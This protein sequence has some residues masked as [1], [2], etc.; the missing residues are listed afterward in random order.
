[1][2]VRISRIFIAFSLLFLMAQEAQAWGFFTHKR[3]NRIAVF[4]LPPEMI[5]FYKA[6]IQF[7]TENAVNPDRRRYAVEGEA[8]RHYIDLDIYGENAFDIIPHKWEDAVAKYSEDTLLEY[9]IV[10]WHIEK[11]V[12][13]LTDAMRKRD[14]DRILLL[15]AD[16]GHYV[17]DCNVPLHTTENYNGHMTNQSGIHGFWESRLPELFFDEYDLFFETRATYEYDPLE[18]AWAAV[19]NAH[20]ALD[21][22]FGF[23]KQLTKEMGEDQ[24]WSF[25]TRGNITMKVY[26]VPFSKAYHQRLNGQV[27]RHLRASIKMTADLWYTCWL[28]AGKPDLKS[29]IPKGFSPEALKEL[30]EE[31][32]KWR[33]RKIKSREHESNLFQPQKVDPSEPQEKIVYEKIA[34]AT[35][36]S[37]R[38]T[39]LHTRREEDE[40]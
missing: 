27:E 13:R 28:N 18:R 1:M 19:K 35:K 30:E 34:D 14:S 16:L 15:S 23:E 22:V 36:T 25:E 21:S 4:L 7:L 9:G 2:Q 31:E 39:A 17:G 6:H 38:L 5:G 12:I 26:S 24:K 11:M 32:K 33:E 10:P 3:I 8:P 20:I 40:N 29:L 37:P